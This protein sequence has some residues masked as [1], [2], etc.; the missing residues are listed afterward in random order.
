MRERH[1]GNYT[2]MQCRIWSE[3]YANGM[4][5]DLDTPPTTSMFK[6]AGSSTPTSKKKD[7]SSPKMAQALTQAASAIATA[8]TPKSTNLASSTGI[9]PAKVIDN[10]TKCYKQLGDLQNLKMQGLLTDEEYVRE[11]V[12]IM[13]VLNKLV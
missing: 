13:G 9:S 8:L 7:D 10:R 3:M 2:Q 5:T 1:G 12:S 4:H 11:R 6:R